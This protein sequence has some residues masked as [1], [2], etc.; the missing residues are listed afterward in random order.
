MTLTL[1]ALAWP[2]VLSFVGD[3]NAKLT[4]VGNHVSGEIM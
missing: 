3:L 1:T 2:V 4:C